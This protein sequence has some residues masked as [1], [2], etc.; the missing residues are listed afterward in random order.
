V[1]AV[2]LDGA[3]LTV[4]VESALETV[5]PSVGD[6]IAGGGERPLAVFTVGSGEVTGVLSGGAGVPAVAGAVAVPATTTVTVPVPL[7]ALGGALVTV[8]TGSVGAGAAVVSEEATVA[9]GGAVA[10][11]VGAGSATAGP[12]WVEAGLLSVGGLAGSAVVT[13]GMLGCAG[14]IWASACCGA[15]VAGV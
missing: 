4:A 13:A 1:S 3:K 11:T 9:T 12:L 8:V 15:P 2:T 7:L 6:T 14:W 10:S 5:P